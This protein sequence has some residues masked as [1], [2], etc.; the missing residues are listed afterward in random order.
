MKNRGAAG[1]TVGVSRLGAAAPRLKG[2]PVLSVSQKNSRTIPQFKFQQKAN[3][4][5]LKV[6]ASEGAVPTDLLCVNKLG[7]RW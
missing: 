5:A 1:K 7:R 3:V 2:R 6:C 4:C